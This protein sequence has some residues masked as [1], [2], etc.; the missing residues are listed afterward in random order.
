MQAEGHSVAMTGDGVNDILALR[1]ADCSVAIAEGSDAA[2]QVSQL[3]LLNSD[4]ASLPSVL[5][6]GRRVVNNITRV[7]SIFFVKTVYSVLLSVVCILCNMPFPFLPIQ[8]TLIDAVVEAY[9]AFLLS[10]EP[11]TQKIRGTFLREVL[12]LCVPNA[13]ATRCV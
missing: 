8:I 1:E 3:V 11:S 13:V 6:E 4:F 5:G 10:F 2:R 12:R 7:A 9:P